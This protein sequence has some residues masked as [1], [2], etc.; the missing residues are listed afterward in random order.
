VSFSYAENAPII[1][2][3]SLH[4]APGQTIALVGPTG[5]GK[6]T[7]LNLLTRFYEADHGTIYL[8]ETPITELSKEWLRDHTGYVTQESF[9]FNT[10]IRENLRLAKKDASDEEIWAA[11]EAA[12]AATFIRESSEGLDTVAGE[13]GIR[14]SGGEKQRLSIARA[15]LKNPPLLLLDESTSALDNETERLVQSALE[16]LRQDRTCFV[17]AHRLSTVRKADCIF[18][19]K[20]GKIEESGTH[21][22]LLALDGIYAQLAQSSLK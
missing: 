18:V 8:D 3:V 7:I 9:L 12:N 6:S 17:I 5:A 2:E 13:R 20:H 1:H 11:L 4:A 15:L 22:Q 14:F 21:E 19:L 10:T 16:N